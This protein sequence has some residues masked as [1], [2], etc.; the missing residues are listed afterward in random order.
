MEHP[1]DRS[2]RP[3]RR[4]V[5]S[6]PK[7]LRIYGWLTAG[8]D[9]IFMAGVALLEADQRLTAFVLVIAFTAAVFA[10]VSVFLW[11]HPEY[12]L[13]DKLADLEERTEELRE[14]MQSVAFRE[15]VEEIVASSLGQ[16]TLG[17]TDGD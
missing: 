13:V 9:G 5:E 15:R 11:R 4:G 6:L 7:A 14:L 12:V 1:T 8:V 3:D 16:D 2:T 10:F 17:E